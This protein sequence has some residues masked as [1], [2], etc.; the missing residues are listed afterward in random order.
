MLQLEID[1]SDLDHLLL[2]EEEELDYLAVKI[3]GVN[4]CLARR[5]RDHRSDLG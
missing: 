4:T 2:I 3:D 1:G 5:C